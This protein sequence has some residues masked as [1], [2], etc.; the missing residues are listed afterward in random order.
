MR[1]PLPATFIS[2]S[3]I[4]LSKSSPNPISLPLHYYSLQIPAKKGSDCTR[5][6]CTP[7][8]YYPRTEESTHPFERIDF[9]LDKVL[10]DL[11]QS[12]L[13]E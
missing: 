4:I 12:N 10:E 3:T 7:I 2:P 9:Y 11:S 8:L 13:F 6:A 1:Y 5:A